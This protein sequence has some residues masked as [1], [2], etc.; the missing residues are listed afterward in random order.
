MPNGQLLT[1]PQVAL[2]LSCSVRTV[3]RLVDSGDLTPAQKLPGPNGA[4]LFSEDDVEAM[5]RSREGS[6]A[7]ATSP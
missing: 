2:R 5:K 4:F 7:F 1:S 6:P 3:H